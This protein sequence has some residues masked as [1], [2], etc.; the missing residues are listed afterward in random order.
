ME[1]KPDE[2]VIVIN[3]YK[4]RQNAFTVIGKK[5]VVVSVESHYARRRA[6][7]SVLKSVEQRAVPGCAFCVPW[8]ETISGLVVNV[9]SIH[10]RLTC[11]I[12]QAEITTD[13][14]GIQ[15][16]NLDLY[17]K[18]CGQIVGQIALSVAVR[19]I[20]ADGSSKNGEGKGGPLR[21]PEPPRDGCV[22]VN[23]TPTPQGF[24]FNRLSRPVNWERLR[25]INLRRYEVRPLHSFP[26]TYHFVL[27]VGWWRMLTLL[28]YY[29]P[30]MIF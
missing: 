11:F 27:V 17:I 28:H 1:F 16:S 29:T 19:H 7:D 25:S 20:F 10:D 30:W 21:I 5:N 24:R 12:G 4:L 13:C 14:F 8:A 18:N 2:I 22:T 23:C 6:P 9:H 15:P 3:R 26:G